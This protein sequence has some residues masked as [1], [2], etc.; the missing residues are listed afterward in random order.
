MKK[1]DLNRI[2]NLDKSEKLL[3][4]ASIIIITGYF[5]Y[6]VMIMPVYNYYQVNK[7]LLEVQKGLSQSKEE[8]VKTFL[9]LEKKF[10]D[11]QPKLEQQKGCFFTDEEAAA[12]LK[13]LDEL[14]NETGNDLKTLK[15]RRVETIDDSVLAGEYPQRYKRNVLEVTIEGSYNSILG[16]FKKLAE[17]KQVLNVN[18][19]EMSSQRDEG[20]KLSAKFLLNIYIL[21][22]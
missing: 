15:P 21:G 3:L 11:L 17:S 20:G 1:L 9:E 6:K 12:F 16:Y 5:V 18:K 7:K 19:V 4:G 8:K 22:E 10:A 13:N 2:Y 14:S